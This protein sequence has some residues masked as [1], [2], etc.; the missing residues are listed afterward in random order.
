M[1]RISVAIS[2]ARLLSSSVY[3]SNGM[4]GMDHVFGYN[5]C[6]DDIIRLSSSLPN[7]CRSALDIYNA[8]MIRKS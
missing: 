3:F 5:K 1:Y 6:G 2:I 8:Q 4:D 7:P